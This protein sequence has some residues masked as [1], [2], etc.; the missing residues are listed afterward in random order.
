MSSLQMVGQLQQHPNH[1][2]LLRLSNLKQR[3]NQQQIQNLRQLMV[4]NLSRL[5]IS[6]L[7]LLNHRFPKNMN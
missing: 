1:P 4:I 6:Q 2:R 5:A 3:N 7:L